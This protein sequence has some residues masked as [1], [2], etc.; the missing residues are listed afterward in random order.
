MQIIYI[1]EIS[2]RAPARDVVD[3]FFFF[4]RCIFYFDPRRR[5]SAECGDL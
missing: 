2:I 5:H 1:V 4:F 3:W